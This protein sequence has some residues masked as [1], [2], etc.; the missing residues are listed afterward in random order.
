VRGHNY[1]VFVV[2]RL[3]LAACILLVIASGVREATF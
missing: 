1:T 3:V 2:Y